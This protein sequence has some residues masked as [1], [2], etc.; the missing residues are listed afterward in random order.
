MLQNTQATTWITI[1]FRWLLRLKWPIKKNKS[2]V[3]QILSC[4]CPCS[5]YIGIHTHTHTQGRLLGGKMLQN[6]LSEVHIEKDAKHDETKLIFLGPIRVTD[7]ISRFH[8]RKNETGLGH[9]KTCLPNLYIP[10]PSNCM[11][12]DF[13]VR[14]AFCRTARDRHFCQNFTSSAWIE[15]RNRQKYNQKAFLTSSLWQHQAAKSF[16]ELLFEGDIG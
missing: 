1:Y 12:F 13:W 5:D 15:G 11:H 2:W 9:R 10:Y 6:V 14:K 4:I 16:K 8:S 7:G 3:F